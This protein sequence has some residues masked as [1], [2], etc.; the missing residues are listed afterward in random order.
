ML[1]PG[2]IKGY[3]FQ[4]AG[5]GLYRADEVDNF[6]Q[7]VSAAYEKMYTENGSLIQ[8]VNL[9]ADKVKAYQEE[10][11]LIKKTLLVAQK[12]ADEIES[13][14][15]KQSEDLVS[16]AE[17][18]AQSTNAAAEQRA[19]DLLSAAEDRARKRLSEATQ[20]SA[21]TLN[22]ARVTAEKTLETAKNK[23]AAILGEA[24]KRAEQ[25]LSETKAKQDAVL[26]SLQGEVEKERKALEEVRAQSRTFKDKLTASYQ[27]Q[28]NATNRLLGFVDADDGIAQ[29]AS[30]AAAAAEPAAQPEFAIADETVDVDT[31]FLEQT[32]A[33]YADDDDL[34]TAIM[35]EV[36]PAQEEPTAS[37]AA[38]YEAPVPETAVPEQPAPQPE[39]EPQAP[40][41][42]QPEKAQQGF[43]FVE[44][45]GSFGADPAQQVQQE[46]LEDVEMA[47]FDDIFQSAL[48]GEP[49]QAAPVHEPEPEFAS[50]QPQEDPFFALR[51]KYSSTEPEPQAAE[52]EPAFGG[53]AARVQQSLPDEEPLEM[54]AEAAVEPI[55]PQPPQEEHPEKKKRRLSLFARYED[56]DEDEDDEEEDDE[57][58][59]EDEGG[60]RGFFRK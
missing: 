26:G 17:K 56:D 14:S 3:Q 36:V 21:D 19:K 32:A 55:P 50:P 10:E 29:K 2:Q 58:D 41:E 11:E 16:S 40:A 38:S 31:S 60:F 59:D 25:I 54:P 39:P 37:E 1:T 13:T 57:D 5:D 45:F 35:E 30:Q 23:A 7:A 44:G 33:P 48:A 27:E 47:G 9:L 51:S 52:P 22:G 6:I 49:E 18:R 53:F 20:Q 8:R 4:L 42:P 12:K 24:K 34:F 43:S 15:R 28:L 46:A